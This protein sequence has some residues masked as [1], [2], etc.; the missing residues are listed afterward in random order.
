MIQSE[1]QELRSSNDELLE[2]YLT[3]PFWET[4]KN[5]STLFSKDCVLEFP[6][7]PPGMPKIF[8]SN[9]RQLL[10]HWLRRTV[11]DWSRK[12]VIKY[13]T[14]DPTRY[15][16]ESRTVATVT[17]G[18]PWERKFDCTHM[19]LV[20]I[21]DK[22]ITNVRTWSDPLAYYLGAGINLPVFNYDGS[23]GEVQSMPDTPPK[24]PKDDE[25]RSAAVS[26][27]ILDCNPFICH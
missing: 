17:W 4:E 22:K 21:Q 18:G 26:S 11:K 9:K 13:P 24:V 23:Y 16:V 1:S 10:F 15:W 5:E 19:E 7:A 2:T 6:Y 8:P 3:T 27:A 12:D 20:I 25:E 14:T